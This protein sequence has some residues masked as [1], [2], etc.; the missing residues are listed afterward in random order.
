MTSHPKRKRVGIRFKSDIL[1]YAQIDFQSDLKKFHPSLA[2]V[3]LN[4]SFKGCN[5]AFPAPCPLEVGATV[6]LQVGKL[7]PMLAVICWIKTYDQ[8]LVSVGFNYQ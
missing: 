5:L 3:I 7:D 4:E 6:C 8:H 1:H 2:A